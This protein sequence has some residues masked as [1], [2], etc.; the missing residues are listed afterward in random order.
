MLV[1]VRLI[2]AAKVDEK[3]LEAKV[4]DKNRG[5]VFAKLT[6][7]PLER[8]WHFTDVRLIETHA[9]T[10]ATI[11]EILRS[12]SAPELPRR[13]PLPAPPA[14]VAALVP[15][16][17]SSPS[18]PLVR[19]TRP[20]IETTGQSVPPAPKAPEPERKAPVLIS[21]EDLEMPRRLPMRSSKDPNARETEVGLM[22]KG[23][24]QRRGLRQ[25]DLAIQ[26]FDMNFQPMLSKIEFGKVV[27]T[28]DHLVRFAEV[29]KLD[30]DQLIAARD[31]DR[32]SLAV[33]E[34]QREQQEKIEERRKRDRERKQVL[35][36]ERTKAEGRGFVPRPAARI[37]ESEPIAAPI[38]RAKPAAVPVAVQARRFLE[39]ADLVEALIEIVPM[40]TDSEM[41]KVWFRCARELFELAGS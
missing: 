5:G 27:A 11:G 9:Q 41:R 2:S 37:V 26:M 35:R 29:L 7:S 14:L 21:R 40:P 1:E 38:Q 23:E 39:L 15:R 6:S 4:V 33:L 36:E 30:L 28:D 24:R 17:A 13:E 16:P 10:T 32:A 19:L 20:S 3:W 18:A 22:V 25:L 8:F 34:Q 31:R 12:H